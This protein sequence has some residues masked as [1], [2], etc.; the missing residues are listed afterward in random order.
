MEAHSKPLFFLPSARRVISSS[1]QVGLTALSSLAHETGERI[2]GWSGLFL[3]QLSG[4]LPQVAQ[5]ALPSSDGFNYNCGKGKD[6]DSLQVLGGWGFCKGILENQGRRPSLIPILC[7]IGLQQSLSLYQRGPLQINMSCLVG[8]DWANCPADGST[9]CTSQGP[10]WQT[11][12]S[13]GVSGHSHRYKIIVGWQEFMVQ[14][15]SKKLYCH[16]KALAAQ[17]EW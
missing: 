10:M 15:H 3:T 1:Q 7:F 6:F 8:M 2:R 5:L 11:I 17:V 4:I 16:L 9:L 12:A 13:I 14:F